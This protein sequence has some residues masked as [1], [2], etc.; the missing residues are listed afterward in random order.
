[1]SDNLSFDEVESKLSLVIRKP[2]DGK[3]FICITNIINDKKSIHIVMTM[4][5]LSASTQFLCR[6][7]E[8]IGS[9]KIIVFNSKKDTAGD[10]YYA[11]TL[12]DVWRLITKHPDIQVIVCCANEIRIKLSVID[13]IA[14]ADDSEIFRRSNRMFTIH[15]DE[16][17]K[18]IP[19]NQSCIRTYNASPSVNSIIG[20]SATP[21]GI[22]SK[23]QA[24]PL[25]HSIF[26]RD[27]EKELDIIRSR[28]YFG[29]KDCEFHILE[30]EM[31]HAH[32]ISSAN[33]NPVISQTALI[34]SG[35]NDLNHKTLFG[36]KWRFDLGNELLLLSTIYQILTR[37][38][39]SADSFSYHF[40]PGYGRKATHYEIVD[41]LLKIC[42]NANI[43]SVNGNGFELYRIRA[44]DNK[45]YNVNSGNSILSMAS[46][47][48]RA[49]LGQPSN[50]IQELIKLTPNCPTFITGFACV[51]MSVTLINESLGNFDSVIM[52]HQHYSRDKLYQLCRFLCNYTYWSPAGRA[53]IK[54]TQFYSLTTSVKDICLDYEVTIEHISA[55]CTGK[56]CSLRDIGG[57]EP[58][59]PSARELKSLDLKS[60]KLS[61]P[62]RTFKQFKV[63]EGNDEEQWEKVKKFYEVITGK[64]LTKKSS[65]T[66][67]DGFYECSTTAGV[68]KQS[69]GNIKRLDKQ[70]WWSLFQLTESLSYARIFVGYDN[71]DD[72]SEYTI[73]IKYAKLEDSE[74]NKSILHK[75]ANKT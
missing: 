62:D 40:V 72:P 56:N 68:V 74:E 35:M 13:L 14:R 2:Q 22:W 10:C 70:S 7:A 38:R 8:K 42:P 45:S 57:F 61:D 54:H 60:I 71:L 69:I 26:I 59:E 43:I 64:L 66:Q 30:E 39:I 17:H 29:V 46:S 21:D 28:Y 65:P 53:N 20:Y 73:F 50:M 5:T 19:A 25:F 33:I 75:Y 52:A 48:D 31:T 1:M 12:E 49:R 6:I 67:V 36:E 15:I 4:N 44:S 32:V 27:V 58:E 9:K 24:D 18:Y 23:N 37:M 51:G 47:E 3:T 34:R 11:R 16:A 55:E 41:L 63:Y